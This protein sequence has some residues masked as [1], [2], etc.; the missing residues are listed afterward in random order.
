MPG[1]IR[2]IRINRNSFLHDNHPHPRGLGC[3]RHP[4]LA[5]EY[6]INGIGIPRRYGRLEGLPRIP[7]KWAIKRHKKTTYFSMWL[8]NQS[9]SEKYLCPPV[10]P[11]AFLVIPYGLQQMLPLEIGPV[12]VG[13]P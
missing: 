1:H 4:S 11:V 12:E 7:K 3:G 5:N 13:Y 8:V 6:F 9:Q 2:P 10:S